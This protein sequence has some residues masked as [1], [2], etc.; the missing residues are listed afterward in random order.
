MNIE[1]PTSNIER[2]MEKMKKFMKLNCGATRGASAC[3]AR[4]ISLFDVRRW[5]F[6][7]GCSVYSAFIYQTKNDA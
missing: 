3:A 6:D 4:A 5:A 1:H 2:P 7:V